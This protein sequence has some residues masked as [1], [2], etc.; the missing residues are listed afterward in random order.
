MFI[1][2]IRICYLTMLHTGAQYPK[3]GRPPCRLI[4]DITW[5]PFCWCSSLCPGGPSDA[6]LRQGVGRIDRLQRLTTLRCVQRDD[7]SLSSPLWQEVDLCD[8]G[9]ATSYYAVDMTQPFMKHAARGH[10]IMRL[11][12][13]YTHTH[14]R[15]TGTSVVLIETSTS[16]E[17]DDGE[18]SESIFHRR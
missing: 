3:I 10:A 17:L 11:R 4:K 2:L 13:R 6:L 9:Y 16:Y 12:R 18:C 5:L 15:F 14:T 1:L 7:G 8:A